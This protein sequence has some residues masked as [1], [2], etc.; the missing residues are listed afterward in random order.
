MLTRFKFA[1]AFNW[2]SQ[3]NQFFLLLDKPFSFSLAPSKLEDHNPVVEGIPNK[4]SNRD[5][6]TTPPR[7]S[8]HLR[9]SLWNNNNSTSHVSTI[10]TPIIRPTA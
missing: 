5:T 1:V 7:T 4:S 2:F 8:V 3:N 9:V 6:A 10:P